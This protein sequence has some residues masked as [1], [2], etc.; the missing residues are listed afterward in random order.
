M[1]TQLS[2][3]ANA[4]VAICGKKDDDERKIITCTEAV[5][6]ASVVKQNCEKDGFTGGTLWINDEK[7]IRVYDPRYV[8]ID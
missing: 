4:A 6:W 7:R 5:L 3:V 2:R 8:T 1:C